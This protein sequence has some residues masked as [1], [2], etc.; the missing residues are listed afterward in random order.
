MV[1]N[2]AFILATVAGVVA[3]LATVYYSIRLPF[4]G[5]SENQHGWFR[6]NPFNAV[7]APARLSPKGLVLR[8]RLLISIGCFVACVALGALLGLIAKALASG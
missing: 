6:F 3:G 5:K 2:I 4:H 1:V 7:F 8:R